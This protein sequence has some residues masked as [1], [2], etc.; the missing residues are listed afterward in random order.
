MNSALVLGLSRHTN[1]AFHGIQLECHDVR[2]NFGGRREWAFPPASGETRRRG[3]WPAPGPASPCPAPA[4]L[5]DSVQQLH[6]A[7]VHHEAQRWLHLRWCMHSGVSFSLMTSWPSTTDVED[8]TAQEAFRRCAAMHYLRCS[9]RVHGSQICFFFICFARKQSRRWN[10]TSISRL[11]EACMEFQRVADRWISASGRPS[12]RWVAS[13]SFASGTLWV[14]N[15]EISSVASFVA[16]MNS[17]GL[18]F[19]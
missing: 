3:R 6:L 11:T 12:S 19:R 14:R 5:T 18:A 7:A 4:A 13:R 10:C 2:G 16:S 9:V 8:T 17:G 1:A 15:H